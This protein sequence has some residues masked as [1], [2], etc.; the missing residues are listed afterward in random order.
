[1]KTDAQIQHDVLEELAWEPSVNAAGLRVD[2]N[3]GVVTLTGHVGSHAEKWYAERAA[4]RV[5]G[6]QALAVQVD[7]RLP[8]SSF[9][10][11]T[12]IARSGRSVLQ[13][14][15]SPPQDRVHLTVEDG[16]VTLT[17]E[18]E[19]DYQRRAAVGAVRFLVGVTGV[20][21]RLTVQTHVS[22]AAVKADIESS[23]RRRAI[24]E[25]P[26]I[27]VEVHGAQ[28]TLTGNVHSWAERELARHSAWGAPG[29]HQVT[30]HMTLVA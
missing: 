8:E 23:L 1:M 15:T 12:D 6:V 4:H 20:T 10:L 29:V 24:G 25:L 16:W 19:W 30:D 13:W 5:S 28:V 18:V 3:D 9:R 27:Q 7:V 2:A 26:C 14:S 22:R 11:D 17:G 21:D